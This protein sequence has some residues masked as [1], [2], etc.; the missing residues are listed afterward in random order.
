MTGT[1][2]TGTDTDVGKTVVACALASWCRRQGINVGV[3]K[4]IATGARRR[5]VAGRMRLVSDDAL[6]LAEAAG[7]QDPMELI[8]PICFEE[9]LAPLTAAKRRG[10]TIRLAPVLQAFQEL[11]RRHDVLIVEGI[12]GL[13]VPLTW[14]L[15]VTD[16]IRRLR[17]PVILVCRPDLGTLNH[18]LL[19][20]DC[21]RQSRI[22]VRGLVMNPTRK[23][24]KGASGIAQ[25]TN[26]QLL[27]RLGGVPI[28]ASFPWCQIPRSKALLSDT[29]SRASAIAALGAAADR[30]LGP[31]WG[32]ALIQQ[33]L[34]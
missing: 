31:R 32:S 23:P 24:P 18:T 27:R 9:P 14:R 20:L 26:P 15:R 4:P 6:A 34:Q 7:A 16:L 11:G 25:R 13:L 12:G 17:L 29:S 5:R 19:S 3:M 28:V 8:N 33:E 21:A 30:A 1:F 22:S 10:E 2:I